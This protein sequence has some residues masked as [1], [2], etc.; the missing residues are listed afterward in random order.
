MNRV[1]VNRSARRFAPLVVLTL[2]LA[3][4]AAPAPAPAVA[5]V[6]VAAAKDKPSAR[7]GKTT[8]GKARGK[9]C[10]GELAGN[11]YVAWKLQ[12]PVFKGVGARAAK[13][14]KARIAAL[15]TKRLNEVVADHNAMCAENG[16]AGAAST[17][18]GVFTVATKYA[19]VHKGRYATFTLDEW[20]D[21]GVGASS[22]R[23]GY[24]S[25]TLDLKTGQPAPLAV[26]AKADAKLLAARVAW[27]LANR[28]HEGSGHVTGV[29]LGAWN[30][31]PKG[32]K[33]WFENGQAGFSCGFGAT[34]TT[35]AWSAIAPE[36]AKGKT[37]TT[38][39]NKDA[40]NPKRTGLT[41]VGGPGTLYVRERAQVKGNRVAY[42]LCADMF[43]SKAEAR[44]LTKNSGQP[45]PAR[46]YSKKAMNAS[47]KAGAQTAFGARGAGKTAHVFPKGDGPV[48]RLT[49]ASRS[50]KARLVNAKQVGWFEEGAVTVF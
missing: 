28:Y 12:T 15:T 23:R 10:K 9:G 1:P 24:T 19:A 25:Y 5:G 13:L 42:S 33:F 30:P 32:L 7:I 27:Q 43:T 38:Y 4:I 29:S 46:P 22:C 3:G 48:Y 16:G 11:E 41:G 35:V 44:E 14:I 21:P 47:C 26:F 18:A 50:K 20:V 45:Y 39:L 17:A 31:S 36:K 6:A 8:S 2:A 34:N 40:R 49:F 37:F